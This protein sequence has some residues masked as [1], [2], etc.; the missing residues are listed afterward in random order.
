MKEWD[1]LGVWKTDVLNNTGVDNRE[2]M[3]QGQTSVDQHHTETWY[4]TVRPRMD[5]EQPGSDV[6]FF[7]FGEETGNLVALNITHGAMAISAAS[8]QLFL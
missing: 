6:G 2:E 1:T 5:K 3:L 7:W 8:K 4:G